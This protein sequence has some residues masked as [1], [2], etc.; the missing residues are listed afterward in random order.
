MTNIKYKN[1]FQ[2]VLKFTDADLKK[3]REGKPTYSQHQHKK[4]RIFFEK[5]ARFFSAWISLLMIGFIAS[6]AFLFFSGEDIGNRVFGLASILLIMFVS[7]GISPVGLLLKHYQFDIDVIREAGNVSR[8]KAE[9]KF[10]FF[11]FTDLVI[12]VGSDGTPI[13]VSPTVFN[14]FEKN[15]VYA[16]YFAG[17]S[18]IL[19]SVE[20]ISP[21]IESDPKDELKY[22]DAQQASLKSKKKKF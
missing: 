12:Q 5:Y 18:K 3:N 10:L 15:E 16:I 11:K 9:R 13:K 4:F 14:A 19:L 21:H 6:L 7:I 2:R 22:L 20:Q 17:K 1:A 8:K